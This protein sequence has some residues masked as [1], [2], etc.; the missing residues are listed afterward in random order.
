MDGFFR[1]Y[2]AYVG[3][4]ESPDIYH[5]WVGISVVATLLGRDYYLPFGH[6]NIYPNQ[7]ILLQGLPGVRKST[8]LKIGTKL[9]KKAGYTRFAPDRMSRQAFLEEMHR[10]NQPENMGMKLEDMLDLDLNMSE[11]VYQMAIHATEFIDFIGQH[12]TDY[13]MLLTRLWDNEDEYANPKISKTSV[14]VMSPTVNML[15]ANTPENLN[16]AFPA[17]TMDTGTLSRIIF[18]YSP[19]TGKHILIPSQPDPKLE[20]VVLDRLKEIQDKVKGPATL[21]EGAYKA[22][23]HIYRTFSRFPLQDPRFAYYNGRRQTHLMKLLLV[24]SAM[25]CSTVIEQD[26][27]LLANT[28]LTMTEH[29]M[30]KALGHFGRSRHSLLINDMLEWIR[31]KGELVNTPE[32][33]TRF[34]SD[35]GSETEFQRI[36]NDL[37]NS[38][39]ISWVKEGA[40]LLGMQVVDEPFPKWASQIVQVNAL[41]KQERSLIGV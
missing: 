11:L 19:P 8:A 37:A 26:D 2:L 27:V 28:I 25:R 24:V 14:K 3:E 20:F 12:D 15:A 38:G 39:K 7:Y 22:L 6:E 40:H 5:R 31:A 30:P 34:I 29:G 4:T 9:L 1:D 10:M 18:V 17:N 13:L 36:V 33:Y 23:D 21:T 16:R 32:L 41:T 35:V